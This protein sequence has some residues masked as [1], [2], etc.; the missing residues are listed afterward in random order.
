MGIVRIPF[1]LFLFACVWIFSELAELSIKALQFVAPD[2]DA[3]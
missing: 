3:E 2:P 1:A